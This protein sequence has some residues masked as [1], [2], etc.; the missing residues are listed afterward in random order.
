MRSATGRIALLMTP[1][2]W[3]KVRDAVL[4][5]LRLKVDIL[6]LASAVPDDVTA[7]LEKGRSY[8]A[9]CEKILRVE[10]K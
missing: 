8:C 3:R 5:R 1:E 4:H 6:Q 9:C 7:A 10:R 2:R